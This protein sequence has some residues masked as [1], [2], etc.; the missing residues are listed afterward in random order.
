MQERED[1]YCVGERR[2]RSCWTQKKMSREK[3]R[4][5]EEIGAA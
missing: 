2:D 5:D 4:R 1:L 3:E